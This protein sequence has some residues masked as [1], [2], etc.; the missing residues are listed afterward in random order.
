MINCMVSSNK[1]RLEVETHFVSIGIWR[2]TESWEC[3]PHHVL[4]DEE[5]LGAEVQR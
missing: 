1:L 5:G 4:H 3:I 2:S